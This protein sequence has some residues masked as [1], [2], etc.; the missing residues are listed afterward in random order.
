MT[1]GVTF[2]LYICILAITMRET[3]TDS[4]RKSDQ[5]LN[6]CFGRYEALKKADGKN[7]GKTSLNHL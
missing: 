1:V 4:D 6:K 3:F 5:N 7:K 2:I